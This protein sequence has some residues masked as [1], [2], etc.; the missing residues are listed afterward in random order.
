MFNR[1]VK[2][3]SQKLDKVSYDVICGVPYA[4]LALVADI[5]YIRESPL[6]MRRDKRKEHGTG[7]KIEGIIKYGMR[8]IVIEDVVTTATSLFETIQ[9]LENEHLIVKDCVVLFDRQQG[10][11]EFAE[12]KGYCMHILFS[13][14]D[15][16][17]VLVEEGKIDPIFADT[18]LEWTKEHQVAGVNWKIN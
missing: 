16:M 8:T 1:V 4:A 5:A 7:K 6:I 9:D 11:V 15:F 2:L 13:I 10:G 18:I 3:L 17:R 12:N 14:T